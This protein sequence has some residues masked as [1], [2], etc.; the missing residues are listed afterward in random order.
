[1]LDPG[2][3]TARAGERLRAWTFASLIAAVVA[4][5]ALPPVASNAAPSRH[6][7]AAPPRH[8]SWGPPESTLSRY[9]HTVNPVRTHRLGCVLGR[10]VRHH[11]E[12]PDALVVLAYGAPMHLH[13]RYGASTYGHFANTR[14]IG[15]AAV[16]YGRGFAACLRGSRGHLT[17]AVGTSNFGPEVTNRHGRIWAS[18]VNRA[19]HSLR[20][21][22][23]ARTVAVD[24][25]DDI[26]PGWRGPVATRS[27]IA[28]YKAVTRTPYFNFGG[29][30]ACPPFGWCQGNWTTEDVWYAAWGSGLARPLPEIYSNTGSN[31]LEWYRLSLYS[32]LAHGERMDF[33][34]AM[35]QLQSCWDSHDRCAGIRN[36]PQRSWSQL[37]HVLNHDPRTAQP[38]RYVTNISWQN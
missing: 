25:A 12:S 4:L 23:I 1:M 2:R 28:G 19:N 20:S 22:G 24:G 3:R 11:H 30:A 5:L 18:M 17:L 8:R 13:G 6:H 29:A 9:M 10:R 15:A 26:E 31:A 37:W 14:K 7:R 34:G 27:W 16:A 36:P 38:L 33:A 35:S 32:Y 21:W